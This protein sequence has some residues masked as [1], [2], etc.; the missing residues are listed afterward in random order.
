MKAS[1][2]A[3][4]K[5]LQS[6]YKMIDFCYLDKKH[7]L[8]SNEFKKIPGYLKIGIP[9]II[10]ID[11]FVCI[12]T[13]FSAFGTASE[14]QDKLKGNKMGVSRKINFKQYYKYTCNFGD[15][16]HSTPN[17]LRSINH[18]INLHL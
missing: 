12:R 15:Q 13:K 6:E 9:K 18:D 7:V 4:L 11:E 16:K 14:N 1:N 2:I 8:L 10:N 17:I 3:D 5:S